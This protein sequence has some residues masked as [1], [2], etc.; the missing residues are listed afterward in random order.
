M[1]QAIFDGTHTYA[2]DALNRL[3][4]V[5]Q[6]SESTTYTYNGDGVLMAQQAEGATTRYAQDLAAPLAQVL[7]TS[8][9]DTTTRYVYG[10]DRLAAVHSS[11]QTWYAHDAPGRRAAGSFTASLLLVREATP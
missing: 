8:V 7:A 5:T 3:T 10:R 1:Q 2:Y 6:G 9:G 4:G 11:M